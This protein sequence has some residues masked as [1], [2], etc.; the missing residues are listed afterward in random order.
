MSQTLAAWAVA[1]ALL[2]F[3]YTYFGYPLLL[4]L[5]GGTRRPPRPVDAEPDEWPR[6][7][8][9]VPAYNEEDQIRPLIESLLAID[10]PRDR[11]QILIV[12]DASSDRTDEIVREYEDRGIELL[13]M[14]ERGG[15]TKAENAA[16]RR[17]TGEIVVNTDASIRIAPDALKSLIAV[18]R[19]PTVG[20]ASG[21]DISVG[22]NHEHGNRAE[23]GS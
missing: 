19:D 5:F 15:K 8:I 16:A 9:T 12:S 22:P 13:R 17:L 7:S 11:L 20:L 10:Y 14:E 21:R 18:F 3:A 4:R 6:V 1:L 2:F 23:S